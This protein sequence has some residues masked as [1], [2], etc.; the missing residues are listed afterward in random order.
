MKHEVRWGDLIS[1]RAVY[2]FTLADAWGSLPNLILMGAIFAASVLIIAIVRR[3]L[4]FIFLPKERQ[5]K[6]VLEQITKQDGQVI[7]RWRPVPTYHWGSIAHVI[8]E[9]VFFVGF[10]LAA[11]FSAAVGNVNLWESPIT[12]LSISLV[13]TYVFSTGLQQFGA[14]FFF[15]LSNAMDAGEYWELIGSGIGGRIS[16]ISPFF[17]EFMLLGPEGHGVL[18]RVSMMT[19]MTGNWQRNFYKEKHEPEIMMNAPEATPTQRAEAGALLLG[20]AGDYSSD[21][22]HPKYE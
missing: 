15:A 1:P 7:K 10:V 21:E 13:G 14:Y 12:S 17:V 19:V 9:S 5:R 2:N 3:L 20:E 8:A 22:E 6:F 11:L 18:H 16:R 4:L